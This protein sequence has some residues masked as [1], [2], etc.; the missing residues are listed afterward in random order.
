MPE[1]LLVP[2]VES[3]GLASLLA[4][5]VLLLLVKAGLVVS[6]IEGLADPVFLVVLFLP[7]SEDLPALLLPTWL[8]MTQISELRISPFLAIWLD[9]SCKLSSP[10]ILGS[11]DSPSGRGGSKITEIRRLSGSRISIAKVPHDDTGERMFTIVGTPESTERA[12]MLLYSQLESEKER[13]ESASNSASCT[14]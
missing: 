2:L 4:S 12:L 10:S 9:V 11:A 14:G 8:P 3:G 1:L 5:A 13:R 6:V 7:L